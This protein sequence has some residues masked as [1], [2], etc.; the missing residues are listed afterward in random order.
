MLLCVLFL[1]VSGLPSPV[2]G[3]WQCPDGAPP[4]CRTA[5]ARPAAPPAANSVAVLYFENLARDTS[6]AYIA[7]GLTEEITSRLGQVGRLTVTS[8]TSVRRMRSTAAT[9][10]PGDLGRALNVNYLVNGTVR[11]VGPRLRVTVELLRASTGIQS[12]SS[13]FDRTTEDLLSIQDEIAVAVAA[14]ITG[15]LLPAE[16][17]RL[18]ARPT[19]NPAAYD[20]YLRG[21]RAFTAVS[22]EGLQE[23]IA[24]FEAALRLDPGFTAARGRMAYAYGWAV[25]WDF[26]IAGVPSDSVIARG[27]AAADRALREDSSSADAWTGRGFLEFFREAPNYSASLAALQRAVLLDSG[28]GLAHQNYS[29]VLRRLGDFDAAEAELR[30]SAADPGPFRAQSLADLGFVYFSR[31]RYAEARFWYDSAMTISGSMTSMNV[32]RSRVRLALGDTAGAVADADAAVQSSATSTRIRVQA[33]RAYF[34]AVTGDATGARL[35]LEPVI[36]S[37]APPGQPVTVRVG[38]EI[39]SA[40]VAMGD[41]DRAVAIIERVR[42]RGAW[43]WSYLVFPDFDPIRNDPRFSRIYAEARPVG[44]PPLPFER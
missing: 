39:A 20:L 31:R 32:F 1:S 36:A 15:Q 33:T 40:L 17:A 3:S 42:P 29:T 41:H 25:N 24:A 8:R 28:S 37:L 38:W 4:P 19:T 27:Q 7:D 9:M 14:G 18:Q 13:Q 23:S 26:S 21:S 30:R 16:R 2:S 44:A 35:R 34:D 10:S 11:R 5:V 12:W 22:G 6:D 43:L